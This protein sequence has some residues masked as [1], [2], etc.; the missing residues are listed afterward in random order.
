ME[1]AVSDAVLEFTQEI[2]RALREV[3]AGDSD[4]ASDTAARLTDR[5][6]AL[7]DWAGKVRAAGS[8]ATATVPAL[9]QLQARTFRLARVIRHVQWVRQ[10]LSDI[11]SATV[12]GYE[13]D[14]QYRRTEGVRI[15]VEG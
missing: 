7:E 9:R 14:G 2:D 11:A 12:N 13:R 5:L 10:G 4:Q 6:P 15:A 1:R 8:V 3:E